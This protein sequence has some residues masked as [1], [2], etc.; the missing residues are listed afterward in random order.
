MTYT[1]EL[2]VGF[3]KVTRIMDSEK[4]ED[5]ENYAKKLAKEKGANSF[6]VTSLADQL[7]GAAV[8]TSLPLHDFPTFTF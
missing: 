2:F 1:I 7:S 3:T 8:S 5:A 4:E 6:K